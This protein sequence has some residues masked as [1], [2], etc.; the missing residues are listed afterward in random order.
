MKADHKTV[1]KVRAE[2][3]ARGEI[4][5]VEK[6]KDTKGRKQPAKKPVAKPAADAADTAA[7]SAAAMKAKHAAREEAAKRMTKSIKEQLANRYDPELHA[8]RD[9]AI[10]LIDAGYRAIA[11]ANYPGAGG[12]KDLMARLNRVRDC[13]KELVEGNKS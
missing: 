2:K 10:R 6:R 9:L 5:H 7:S 12:S 4:P 11:K 3:E 8:E 1:G 13:L